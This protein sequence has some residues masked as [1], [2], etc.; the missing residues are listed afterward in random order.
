MDSEALVQLA[1]QTLSCTQK[2]L[3]ARLRVSP[4]QISK[5]KKGEH[6]SQEMEE[7]LRNIIGI[8]DKDPIFILL[9]GSLENAEKWEKLIH[10]L[11][12]NACDGAETGYV[13]EPLQERAAFLCGATLSVLNNIGVSIPKIFPSDLEIN[14]DDDYQYSWDRFESNSYSSLIIKIYDSF[15][16]IWGFYAAYVMDLINDDGLELYGTEAENIE[17]CLIELA[18]AK[19]EIDPKFAPKFTEFKSQ[20]LK[21]YLEWL[22]IVKDKAFR[23]GAPLKAELLN[24]VYKSHGSI[25][26]EAESE[27][28]G[29]NASRLHPDIYM[30]ELLCGMRA[31]HQVLP[32]IMKKL[33]IDQEF[34]FDA[35]AL[36]IGGND[37]DDDPLM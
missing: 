9:A 30:N 4:T 1:L 29:L 12:E 31:I 3:A 15:N 37:K 19:I 25:G 33:G 13:T 23:S 26:A 14:E 24:M 27:S 22:Q 10:H 16:D 28:F 6:L 8:G 32:A 20:T 5:W 21:Q 11:A 17:P 2:D 35:S 7:R 34:K 36:Y 18:A